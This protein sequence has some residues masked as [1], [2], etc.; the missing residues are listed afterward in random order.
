ML[1]GEIAEKVGMTKRAVKYY[2]EKKLLSVKKDANGYRNYTDE[3]VKRLKSISVYRKLG[4]GIQDIRHILETDDQSILQ[5]IYLEKLEEKDIRDAEIEALKLFIEGH[6]C[7]KAD[8]VLD[9]ETINSAIESLIPGEWNDY[10][11]NHFRPFLNIRVTTEEQKQALK[12]ILSYCDDTTIKVPWIMK[13]GIRLAGGIAKDTRTAEEMIS[14]YRDMSE[15]DYA[16]LKENVLKGAKLKSGI[17]KYHP[18]YIAQRKMMKQFQDKGY[19][20]IFI[21]NLKKLSPAYC[22]YK[23]AL[24]QVNNRISQELGLYYDSDYHLVLKE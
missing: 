16:L 2:E 8:E 23:E 24:D 10:F 20:D 1:L 15:A 11:K 9:Y 5:K 18:A 22:E 7:T 12:T 3:D 17:F 21:P 6:D 4:I 14:Y 19:N 13:W